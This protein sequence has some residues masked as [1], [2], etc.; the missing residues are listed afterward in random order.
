MRLKALNLDLRSGETSRLWLK[1]QEIVFNS[2]EKD[3]PT[4][5]RFPLAN[6]ENSHITGATM[7]EINLNCIQ[8][9]HVL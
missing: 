7:I 9:F 1:A 6:Q 2:V 4:L 8:A 5:A 3:S